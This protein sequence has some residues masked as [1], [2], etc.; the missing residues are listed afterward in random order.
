[1]RKLETLGILCAAMISTAAVAQEGGGLKKV[2]TMK[3]EG[4]ALASFD[5]GVVDQQNQRYY[6][7]DRTNGG[8]DVFDTKA[9]KFLGLIGGFAGNKKGE[10]GGPNGISVVNGAVW[11]SDGDSAIKIADPKTMK[12][13]ASVSTGGQKRADESV[14]DA[15][16][17]IFAVV[18]GADDP[19]F[20]TFISTKA[21]H[22][23][24]GKITFDRASD[25]V[26]QPLYDSATHSFYVDVPELDKDKTLGAV[27]Q[28]D[29]KTLKIGKMMNIK[30]CTPTGLAP[31]A[32][33]KLFIGCHQMKT[34]PFISGILDPQSGEF[35]KIEGVGGGDE[36]T[37][38]PAMGQYFVAANHMTGGPVLGVID[39]ATN[40]W[41]QNLPTSKQSHSVAVDETSKRVYVPADNSGDACKGCV[42]VFGK[43]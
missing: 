39:A 6:L 11:A 12:I 30:G 43:E 5:I 40:K 4:K 26:E 8:V 9:N 10:V 42:I 22:K 24:L 15:D 27:A 21:D 23:V 17:Q 34:T 2:A 35:T 37:Y 25:G 18:N 32:N 29:P 28:I 38:S 31:G 16:D 7:A 36:V 33:G 20:L 14:Y 19:P 1:M 3:P 41:V 13:V